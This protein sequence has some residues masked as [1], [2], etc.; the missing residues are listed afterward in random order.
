MRTSLR[1]LAA[2][3][4][5]LVAT[6]LILPSCT[7]PDGVI[8]AANTDPALN[9]EYR[10]GAGDKLGIK[11]FGQAD[12]SGEFDV[13]P[14]GAVSMP[15]IGQVPAANKTMSDFRTSLVQIL[16]QRFLVDPKVSVDVVN[17]RPF[18]ILGQ[19]N[20]PGSYPYK[21]NM[22]MRMAVALGGGYTRR[23][24]EE[25]ILVYRKDEN[26]QRIRYLVNADATVLPG[27]TIDVQRRLF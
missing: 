23:A 17:Y 21:A 11:V 8:D 25:P 13:G 20:S 15:L 19:V 6:L 26:G 1:R 22:S 24:R 14:D 12:M 5:C 7:L 10:L 4:T 3:W 27:D 9:A 2:L 18:F 16:S